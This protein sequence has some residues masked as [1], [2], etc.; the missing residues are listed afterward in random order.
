MKFVARF[1]FAPC[2][3]AALSLAAAFAPIGARAD[4]EGKFA[5]L[6]AARPPAGSSF[7][8]LVNPDSARLS[9]KI[10]DGPV[11]TL[12][13]EAT[14]STYAIVKGNAPFTVSLNGK[15]V[16]TLTVA[17]DSFATLVPRREGQKVVFTVVD[18]GGGSQDALKAE[19]RFYNLAA[20]CPNGRLAVAPA[21]PVLFS[22]VAPHAAAARPIN[23]VSAKLAA[24]CS[25]VASG[26][27][28]LPA[29]QPGDHYSLFLVGTAGKPVLRGQVSATD[30][31]GQ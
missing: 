29:L 14:A 7:V 30:P 2:L 22:A 28:T 15:A 17:P 6:Y 16:A 25:T 12:S 8:R 23:P 19:L 24:A 9:V 27:L 1:V 3:G 20:D 11:Q 18:D 26:A 21:G 5:Q 4:T 13:G 31:Y 10:A